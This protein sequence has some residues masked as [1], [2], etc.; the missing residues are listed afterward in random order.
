MAQATATLASK[1]VEVPLSEDEWDLSTIITTSPMP[2]TEMCDT[3]DGCAKTCA[4]SC[5]SS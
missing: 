3:N 2:I 4:S 5:T 1:T